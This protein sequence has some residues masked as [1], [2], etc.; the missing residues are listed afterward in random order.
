MSRWE[1]PTTRSPPHWE[2]RLQ[3]AHNHRLGTNPQ[4]NTIQRMQ[5]WHTRGY[6]PH[7]DYPHLW[8]SVTFRLAD[9]VPRAVRESWKLELRSMPSAER[10]RHLARQVDSYE[11]AGYG[12][13]IL[14]Q[15]RCAKV[16]VRELQAG[17]GSVYLIA[18]WVVMPNH[19]HVLVGPI[20]RVRIDLSQLTR[21][22]KGVSAREI[23]RMLGRKGGLWLPESFDRWIR[24]ER[25]FQAVSADISRNPV[26]AG[27]CARP[28]DWRWSHAGDQVPDDCAG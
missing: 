28:G 8:Q 1:S 18:A 12:S 6:L 13:C 23:N 2:R 25:H 20:G 5:G 19:V 16:V 11:D 3:P 15:D 14:G 7:V 27:L 4:S 10:E 9:A 24:D 22:W 17:D 26:K 21:R